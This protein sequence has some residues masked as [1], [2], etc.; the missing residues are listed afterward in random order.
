MKKELQ[1]FSLI[2]ILLLLFQLAGPVAC[3]SSA[4]NEEGKPARYGAEAPN[5]A[6]TFAETFP[7]R[8]PGSPMEKSAAEWLVAEVKKMGY[9]PQVQRFQI[10]GGGESQNLLID[11]PGRGFQPLPKEQQINPELPDWQVPEHPEARRVLVLAHYDTPYTGQSTVEGRRYDGIHDNAAGVAAVLEMLS[12]LRGVQ[13]AYHLT[14]V[15]TGAGSAKFAGAEALAKS[16]SDSDLALFDACYNV[17]CIYA[18]DKVYA[19]AGQNSVIDGDHK[20]YR[21]RRKLYEATDIYYDNLL[22][23]NNDFALYTNQSLVRGDLLGNGQNVAYREWSLRQSD[24]T[25]FDRRGV[26]IVFFESG[27]YEGT[28]L[29]ATQKESTDPYFAEVNGIIRG[30]S[31]DASK[32]LIPYFASKQEQD[33]EVFGTETTVATPSTTTPQATGDDYKETVS[34]LEQRVNNVAFILLEALK[35]APPNCVAR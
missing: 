7:E 25:P 14:V 23:T 13:P 6:V 11:I 20:S 18:G 1:R 33:K 4:A 28:T 16:F 21:L 35:K 19:H 26:P 31:F 30:S 15:F 22:L 5:W 27:E 17:D 32:T 10:P 24:H 34:R 29:E 9:N 8:S 3:H 12:R 2:L